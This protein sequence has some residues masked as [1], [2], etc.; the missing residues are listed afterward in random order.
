MTLAKIMNPE[1]IWVI[2]LCQSGCVNMTVI[3]FRFVKSKKTTL[4]QY[5]KYS[6][7]ISRVY[8]IYMIYIPYSTVLTVEKIMTV[9]V[10]WAIVDTT[11]EITSCA[12]RLDNSDNFC[13]ACVTRGV[14]HLH[15]RS[16]PPPYWRRSG[17]SSSCFQREESRCS[18]EQWSSTSS[19][20]AI[21]AWNSEPT[22]IKT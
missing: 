20:R 17:S 10:S 3:H 11:S 15:T 1:K 4:K 8:I 21:P 18:P 6:I 19:D 7:F 16:L 9:I 14:M 13:A 22:D 5:I 2:F 12:L